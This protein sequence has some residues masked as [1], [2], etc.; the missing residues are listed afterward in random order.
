AQSLW[1]HASGDFVMLRAPMHALTIGFFGGLLVA[2]VTRVTQGH[3]GR[4]LVMG[5]LPWVAFI[6][7]QLT[8][9]VRLAAEF[10]SDSALWMALAAALWVAALL[11]WIV[12]GCI[13]YLAPRAD[14][15]PG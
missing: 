11:P 5:A 9:L 14:G 13:I 2:M 10:A 8:V 3:S 1:L 15:Q 6:G 4:P 12:R 7:S